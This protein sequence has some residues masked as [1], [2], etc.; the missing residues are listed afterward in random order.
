MKHL[1]ISVAGLGWHDAQGNWGG[2]LGDLTFKPADSVFPAVTCTA[3]ASFRTASAAKDHGMICN[4]IF[5]KELQKILFWEQ[6]A[7]IVHGK[8]IWEDARSKWQKVAMLFW[9]QSLG[10]S[11]DVILSP[12]PIHKHN[13]GML[14]SNYSKPLSLEKELKDKLG[15]FP[16]YRYWGPLAGCQIGNKIVSHVEETVLTTD[17]DIVFTYL[18]TLDYDLQRYGPNDERCAKSFKL[19]AKQLKKLTALAEKYNS[20]ITVFG[21]Y[22]ISPVTKPPILPNRL[23]RKQGFLNVR[24]IKDKAYPDFYASKA[25]AMVDH[26]IAHLYVRDKDD[27]P[28]LIDL[29]T[30]T[31]EYEEII[32]KAPHLEWAHKGAGELLLIAKKGSWCAYPWWEDPRE[33]PD[34][35]T[36]VDIHN[37][38]GFDPAELFFGKLFPLETC[39]DLSRVKGTHGNKCKIAYAST[40]AEGSNIIEL[41]KSL[42]SYL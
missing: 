38:P 13:G 30:A 41:A 35:A 16:L 8:R 39:Q 22:A 19:L 20:S 40:I 33:A 42:Q 18:P 31:G 6:S 24:T 9:Q 5:H 1:I 7:N 4:G 25:F 10:E 28:T 12:A 26:E 37:K 29:F 17:P 23:L 2:K 3:Q 32:P 15:T 27:I 36:H 21:D 14:M 34:Y 11:A